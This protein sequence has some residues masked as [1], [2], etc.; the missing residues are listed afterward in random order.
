MPSRPNQTPR[1]PQPPQFASYKVAFLSSP[2]LPLIE[3]ADRLFLLEGALAA[4]CRYSFLVDAVRSNTFD[5]K[6]DSV[7]VSHDTQG[8]GKDAGENVTPGLRLPPVQEIRPFSSGVELHLKAGRTP[9]DVNFVY[10][11]TGKP[12]RAALKYRTELYLKTGQCHQR[13]RS[14]ALVACKKGI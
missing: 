6:R 14:V 4:I 8:I 5:R 11:K 13:S 12:F 9:F 3:R 7:G 2:L 10:V 1:P